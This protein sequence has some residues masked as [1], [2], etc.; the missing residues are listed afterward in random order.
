MFPQNPSAPKFTM[1]EIDEMDF[2]FFSEMME[3]E[4]QKEEQVYIDQIW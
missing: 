2:G 1:S 3:V 4:H